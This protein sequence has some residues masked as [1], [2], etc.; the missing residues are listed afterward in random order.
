MHPLDQ[1]IMGQNQSLAAKLDYRRIIIQIARAGMGGDPA[2][3]FD[4]GEFAA[5]RAGLA[6]RLRHGIKHAVDEFCL[7]RGEESMGDVEIF[8][9]RAAG[10]HVGT[11]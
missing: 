4:Q 8:A 6:D 11:G 5:Q 1:R 7:A 3:R 9:D 10:R 2:Q